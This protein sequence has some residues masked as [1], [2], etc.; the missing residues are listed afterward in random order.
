MGGS[1]AEHPIPTGAGG[2]PAG[3][4]GGVP[5][6]PAGCPPSLPRLLAGALLPPSLLLPHLLQQPP[7]PAGPP[8]PPPQQVGTGA[9]RSW[10][11]SAFLQHGCG[12]RMRR[13]W[14]SGLCCPAPAASTLT[15]SSVAARLSAAA[16]LTPSSASPS[17]S[18]TSPWASSTSA[19]FTCWASAPSRTAM[20]C[21]GEPAAGGRGRA[22]GHRQASLLPAQFARRSPAQGGEDRGVVR[23]LGMGARPRG[24]TGAQH[25]R[26]HVPAA[27]GLTPRSWQ[28]GD[29]GCDAAAAGA[30]DGAARPAD[31]PA[32]LP[33]QHHP[34]HRGDLHAAVHDRDS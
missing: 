2:V 28:G 9:S 5:L 32:D 16:H 18:P 19:S 8:I 31:P 34:L 21:T 13:G 4:A 12:R 22:G 11:S 25:T 6:E 23:D 20:S 7:G 15:P 14:G 10:G 29:G 17:P 1:P 26:W 3:R 33:P 27:A 24:V 30:A